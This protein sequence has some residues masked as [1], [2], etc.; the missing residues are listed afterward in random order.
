MD[1]LLRKATKS[2]LLAELE[3]C[4]Q[5][6]LK[7]PESTATAYILDGMAIVQMTKAVH[8]VLEFGELA[9]KY[10]QYITSPFQQPGSN[11]VDVVFDRSPNKPCS[12]KGNEPERRGSS[13]ALKI[14]II[15]P[16]TQV[17]NNGINISVIHK[18]RAI[19]LHSCHILDAKSVNKNFT[20]DKYFSS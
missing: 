5:V 17:Q 7:L 11:R 15:G 20:K 18:I 16:S 3:K 4:V 14:K 10:Y 1:G 19:S 12:I 13:L 8:R 2:V 6:L 9:K